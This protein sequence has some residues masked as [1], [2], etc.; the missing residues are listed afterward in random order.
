MSSD[1]PHD[2]VLE[3]CVICRA[4]E[5]KNQSFA[6]MIDAGLD[7]RAFFLRDHKIV[8]LACVAV[9]ADGKLPSMA[10]VADY[11][12]TWPFQAALDALREGR[13]RGAKTEDFAESALA[14]V[15]GYSGLGDLIGRGPVVRLVDAIQRLIDY[16]ELRSTLAA[17][18]TAK[19]ILLRPD[20]VL[21]AE[22]AISSLLAALAG[23]GQGRAS[24]T[25]GA[26]A[27]GSLAEHDD[28]AANGSRRATW[29][30]PILDA[31][32]PL[33]CGRLCLLSAPPGGGKTSLMLWASLAQ[34]RAHPGSVA[35]ASL[36]MR[37]E[38]LAGRL[39]GHIAGVRT[40]LIETGGLT[41]SQRERCDEARAELATLDVAVRRP[42]ATT[43]QALCSW[44]RALHQRRGERLRLVAVDYVQLISAA[45]SNG[46]WKA[47][48]NDVLT[49]ATRSLMHLSKSLGICILLGSQYSRDGRKEIRGKG[50]E[51]AAMPRP[52]MSDLR[53]SGSL[54]QDA[55]QVLAL[56]QRMPTDPTVTAVQLKHRGGDASAELE[57]S[58]RKASGAWGD[59]LPTY[60]RE[61]TP[62]ERD[63]AEEATAEAFGATYVPSY[64][65]R[66]PALAGKEAACP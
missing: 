5:D 8:W 4:L 52:R 34:A 62:E 17:I 9:A 1:P 40:E 27:A 13:P 51:I 10:T 19:E 46:R 44:I 31:R 2:R 22:A 64:H 26:A 59:H 28:A 29:G 33:R 66:E 30:V 38:D 53:G 47:S 43:T 14:G 18:E 25:L 60:D 61:R 55:D 42:E 15:G 6:E 63:D 7:A 45:P 12:L 23:S 58:W 57:L 65:H 39:I 35:F 41:A 24:T 21:T 3:S 54:E 49:E 50:G 48:E 37:P 32:H 20:G 56:W 16:R 11:L 36:E